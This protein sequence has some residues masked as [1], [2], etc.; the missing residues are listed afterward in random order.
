LIKNC[1]IQEQIIRIRETYWAFFLNANVNKAATTQL[2]GKINNPNQEKDEK[3]CHIEPM[4]DNPPK[5]IKNQPCLNNLPT[6]QP[7]RLAILS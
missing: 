4:I 7:V 1:R 5:I 3:D 6:G 2:I